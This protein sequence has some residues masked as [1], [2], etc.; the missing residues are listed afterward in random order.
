MTLKTSPYDLLTREELIQLLE[1]RDNEPDRSKVRTPFE[2]PTIKR[3][4]SEVLVILFN[5][6]KDP[7]EKAMRV[8]LDYF[9]ADWGYVAIFEEDGQTANFICEA[10]SEWVKVPKDDQSK[11]T[12]FYRAR[13]IRCW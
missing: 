9:N 12:L 10:M 2:T 5:E 7:I 3:I 13:T 1:V 11:L 4:I 6:E 8:L